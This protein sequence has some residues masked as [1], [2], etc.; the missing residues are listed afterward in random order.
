MVKNLLVLLYF[1]E[2]WLIYNA[3]LVSGIQ[4]SDPVLYIYISSVHL[5]LMSYSLQPC[6]LQHASFP[7][8]HQIPELI[9]SHFHPVGNTIQPSHPLSTPSP[10]AFNLSQH[11]GLFQFSSSN[12]MTKVLEFQLQHQ[13]NDYSGLISFRIDL[14]ISLLPKGLSRVFSK[15]PSRVFSNT[16]VQKHQF[17]GTQHSL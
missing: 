3:V 17:F 13:S 10:P 6:G 9:Q 14:L 1:I 16:T 4:H 11:Q 7:V 12:Q 2:I 8:L 15:E 5:S